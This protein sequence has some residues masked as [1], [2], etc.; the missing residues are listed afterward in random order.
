[1]DLLAKLL[2]TTR[3]EQRDKGDTR[4]PRHPL[5]RGRVMLI[6]ESDKGG[7]SMKYGW[8]IGANGLK[9]IG[10]FGAADIR[11]NMLS[12]TGPWYNQLVELMKNGVM[13]EIEPLL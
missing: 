3:A 7:G 13:V 12:F 10:S 9:V 4:N 1:M 6:L 5:Y 11:S 2:V 8:R